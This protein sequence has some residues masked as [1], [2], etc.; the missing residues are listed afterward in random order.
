L[1]Q[2]QAGIYGAGLYTSNDSYGI[3]LRGSRFQLK[4]RLFLDATHFNTRYQQQRIYLR[5]NPAFPTEQGGTNESSEDN[6]LASPGRNRFFEL[7]FYYLLPLGDGRSNIIKE[8]L[9][10]DGILASAPSGGQ[11]WNP[12]VS[13]RSYIHLVPFYQ[14]Q[15]FNTT[16]GDLNFNTNGIKLEFEYDN[17]DFPDNP[18]TGSYQ[19]LRV[20]RDF[21]WGDSSDSWTVLDFHFSKY[22]SLGETA[23]YRQRVIALDF[24]TADTPVLGADTTRHHD[25]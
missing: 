6:Y 14:S 8:Y 5:N 20:M 17:R 24:W 19:E 7:D 21:G 4:N 1:Q 9:L 11:A 25:D 23:N 3:F 13:G 22:Y 16:T 10:A 2:G 18:S 15:V 12:R